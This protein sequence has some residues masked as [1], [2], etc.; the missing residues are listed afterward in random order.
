MISFFLGVIKMSE[1]RLTLEDFRKWAYKQ[2][3]YIALNEEERAHVDH[4]IQDLLAWF[5]ED[6]QTLGHFLTAMMQNDLLET[7]G[8][9]DLTNLKM[10]GFYVR[11]L[12]NY[13]PMSYH[14][15]ALKDFGD[16]CDRYR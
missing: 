12:Y 2:E 9:A 4:M 11:F 16:P 6:H 10:I 7:V 3:E 8:R 14:K 1:W 13:F 5:F 15:K